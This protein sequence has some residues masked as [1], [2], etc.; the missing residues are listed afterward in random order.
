L[1]LTT[2]RRVRGFVRQDPDAVHPLRLLR[3]GG[4]R[5]GEETASQATEE[6]SPVYHSIT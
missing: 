5:R 1:P 4:E 2:F 3:G 6:R